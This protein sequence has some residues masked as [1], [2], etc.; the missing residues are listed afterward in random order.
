MEREGQSIQSFMDGIKRFV[1]NGVI[2]LGTL[3]KQVEASYPSISVS[4]RNHLVKDCLKE[5]TKVDWVLFE[6][7]IAKFATSQ[8][9]PTVTQFF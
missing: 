1:V 5:R 3:L 9:R 8:L 4:D 2:A 6:D 7:M